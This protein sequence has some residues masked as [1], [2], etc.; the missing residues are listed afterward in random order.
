MNIA[1]DFTWYHK[2]AQWQTEYAQKFQKAIVGRYGVTEFKDQFALNGDESKR[3]MGGGRWRPNLR[4]SIGFVGTMA[5][6]ALMCNSEYNEELVR[7]M[8]SLKHEPYE[9]G[10]YDIYYDGLIYLFALL[11][12]SGNYRMN[13]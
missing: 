10:Y 4:H 3:P 7:H 11:H 1:M 6:T 9:D 5:T 8:F 12:L 13:W 2:D